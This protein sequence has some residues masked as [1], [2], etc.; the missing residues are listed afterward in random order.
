MTTRA[1]AFLL[2]LSVGVVGISVSAARGGDTSLA[3]PQVPKAPKREQPV[4]RTT[5]L[6]NRMTPAQREHARLH[7]EQGKNRFPNTRLLDEKL[8]TFLHIQYGPPPDPKPAEEVLKSKACGADAVFIGQVA[9]ANSFPTEDG[10][11]LF[12]DHSVVV[13]EVFRA[14]SGH[15]PALV[16]VTVT[17]IGGELDV[18]GTPV[19][20]KLDD[21]PALQ[22]GGT[23]LF[24][25]DFLPRYKTFQAKD[26]EGVWTVDAAR[27]RPLVTVPVLADTDIASGLDRATVTRWL[28]ELSCR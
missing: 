10:R 27:F 4:D 18:E 13:T 11:L 21:F 23:Y 22:T 7:A 28:R 26:P 25:L 1:S 24:F 14:P 3:V 12:T 6:L 16:P 9:N 8:S 2:V 20:A 5:P 17:R 15:R 19:Y